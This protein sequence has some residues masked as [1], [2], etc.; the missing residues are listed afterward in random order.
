M[1]F[2]L[3]PYDETSGGEQVEQLNDDYSIGHTKQPGVTKYREGM[4]PDRNVPGKELY[5]T[6]AAWF[7]LYSYCCTRFLDTCNDRSHFAAFFFRSYTIIK[8]HEP[9]GSTPRADHDLLYRSSSS[10]PAVLRG[11]VG[12]A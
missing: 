6:R 3:T 2:S 5:R 4:C 8:I 10:S 11:C 9:K 7:M 12:S 1:Y